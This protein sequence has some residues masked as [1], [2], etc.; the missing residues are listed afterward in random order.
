MDFSTFYRPK[1]TCGRYNSKKNIALIYNLIEGVSYYFED[2]SALIIK[3]ILLAKRNQPINLE[4]ITN[5][6]PFDKE[7]ILE[8]MEELTSYG[9]VTKVF[10]SEKFIEEYRSQIVRSRTDRNKHTSNWFLSEEERNNNAEKTYSEMSGDCI[11]SVM[12][13]LTYRCSEQCIHCYNPGAT[14]NS[15]E[16][17]E[18][19]NRTELSI[20]DYKRII[21]ELYDLGIY[22][23][24]LSGGDPFSKDI[25][26][27]IIE[28]LYEKELAFDIFTNGLA[29]VDKVEQLAKYYPR[30]VGISLYS[31]IPKIH[32]SITH[33]LGSY[34]KTLSVIEQCALL[35]IPM[36][37]KCCIMQPNLRSYYTVKDIAA[38]YGI[39]PQFDLN[40]TDSVDG[41]KCA[42]QYLRLTPQMM[43]IVLRDKDLPYYVDGSGVIESSKP[44]DINSSIACNAGINSLCITPEGFV[45]PCCAFPLKL[46]DVNLSSIS[47]ILKNSSNLNWWKAKKLKD[48]EECY[49]HKYCI[50]CQMCPGNNYITNGTPL[51][52]SENNCSLAKIRYNLALKMKEG[53]DP[54]E[55]KSLIEKLKELKIQKPLLHKVSST[56]YR[57]NKG[58][59]EVSQTTSIITK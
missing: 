22:K 40:I 45:Q 13:E 54:L 26:W 39:V 55:G 31:N 9:L 29:I 14:R 19:G 36:N 47:K 1:W 34:K 56:N 35:G 32:E 48:Y 4:N 49:T 43:E 21:D 5:N 28:Y 57:D 27:D 46:G 37:L 18:R 58:I 50:Y 59:K 11:S 42:S 2:Y 3:E 8:F 52:P 33:V 10:P 38:Q 51:K 7:E 53:Y 25:V 41:D 6:L 12:L 30:I 44:I 17:N 15:S 23:V 24:C 16:K 20:I